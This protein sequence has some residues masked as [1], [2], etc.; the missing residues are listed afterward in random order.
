MAEKKAATATPAAAKKSTP[1]AKVELSG[2]GLVV[3]QY[4][5]AATSLGGMNNYSGVKGWT[6]SPATKGA[7]G[8]ITPAAEKARKT[9]ANKIQPKLS[10]GTIA[11][12]LATGSGEQ[13]EKFLSLAKAAQADIKASK[14]S[15]A[16]KALLAHAIEFGGSGERM[17]RDFSALPEL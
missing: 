17:S 12:V 9:Q 7:D 14:Y 1:K 15:P 16:V 4:I 13:F 11:R 8:K 3:K 5:L 10:G 2:K 6:E